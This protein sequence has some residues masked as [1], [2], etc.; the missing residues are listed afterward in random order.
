MVVSK[1]ARGSRV[2]AIASGPC[3]DQ[4]WLVS[5]EKAVSLLVCRGLLLLFESRSAGTW[6]VH[7]RVNPLAHMQSGLVMRNKPTM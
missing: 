2:G 5:F 7:V 1:A 3:K 6:G 4:R